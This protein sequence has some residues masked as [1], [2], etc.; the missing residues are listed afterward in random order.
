MTTLIFGGGIG[1][2][3]FRRRWR[4]AALPLVGLAIGL[5]IWWALVVILSKGSSV[6]AE[7]SPASGL[8]QL[9]VGLSNGVLLRH[10][11][12]SL[13]R[14]A[15]GLA[16]AVC[17]AVP[18]GLLLGLRKRLELAT[19]AVFQFIR[20]ISPLSWMPIAVMVFGVGDLPVFF[21]LS[22]AAVWPILLTIITA[23]RSVNPLYI[24][25][26]QSFAADPLEVVVRIV[27]PAIRPNLLASIRVAVG[28]IWVVLVP[29]EMLGVSS[30][31]G[32]LILDCRDRLAYGELTAA[33]LL[34][35]LIGWALDASLRALTQPRISGESH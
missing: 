4:H 7:F 30:G 15:V 23:V 5:A 29:A 11:G 10:A 12:A 26:A 9:W 13:I 24:K 18:L 35:G 17:V 25:V 22:V 31:L 6:I 21:L 34:I 19:S 16:I 3:R 33:L 8:S 32:Y 14:V 20:M 2:S 1:V 28:L 27:L